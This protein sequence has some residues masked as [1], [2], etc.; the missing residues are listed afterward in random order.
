VEGHPRDMKPRRGTEVRCRDGV[1]VACRLVPLNARV[2]D[3][4]AARHP[5]LLRPRLEDST[6][7]IFFAVSASPPPCSE[8]EDC[9]GR[10]PRDLLR[11]PRA[12]GKRH[13]PD[14]G[15]PQARFS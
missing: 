9:D 2:S 1:E 15:L 11:A 3:P 10:T 7:E 14:N 5:G 6:R 8:G 12:Q 13:Q 4:R